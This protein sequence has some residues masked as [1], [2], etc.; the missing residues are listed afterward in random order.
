[1]AGGA[2]E[3]KMAV[4]SLIED[5]SVEAPFLRMA[6]PSGSVGGGGGASQKRRRRTPSEASLHPVSSPFSSPLLSPSRRASFRREVRHAAA[7]TYLVTRLT[8]TLLRY[9][10]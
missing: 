9:L 7:E 1:M 8:L 6:P 4:S 2:A 3:E 5:G 10:G